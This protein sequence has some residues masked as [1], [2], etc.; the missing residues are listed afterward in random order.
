MDK[1]KIRYIKY[2]RYLVTADEHM[3]IVDVDK[4]F[5]E[6][7]G[8]SPEEA[9]SMSYMSL[10]PEEDIE[11]Q[12]QFVVDIK[13]NR[14]GEGYLEHRMKRK[15]GK[16]GFV[17][18]YGHPVVSED[19]KVFNEIIIADT[20]DTKSYQKSMRNEIQTRKR[21]F[22]I[23]SENIPGGMMIFE[24]DENDH[25][26]KI[27]SA[28]DEFYN[29][30]GWDKDLYISS[31]SNLYA[32]I[33]ILPKYYDDMTKKYA[34][35]K[36][37]LSKPISFEFQ[38]VK[39][40]GDIAWVRCR[41]KY[42]QDSKETGN[43]K[44]FGI[45]IDITKEKYTE[46]E[47]EMKNKLYKKTVEYHTNDCIFRYNIPSQ[48]I[49]L[50]IERKNST[51]IYYSLNDLYSFI[52]PKHLEQFKIFMERLSRYIVETELEVRTRFCSDEYHWCR[53]HANSNSNKEGIYQ[54]DGTVEDIEDIY[55]NNTSNIMDQVTGFY[56]STIALDMA[57]EYFSKSGDECK[58]SSVI[59]LGL[60]YFEGLSEFVGVMYTN[61]IISKIAK[62]I[63][64]VTDDN[65][66]VGRLSSYEFMIVLKNHAHSDIINYVCRLSE[67]IK[68][69][70]IGTNNS[71][72][73]MTA[74]GVS[75]YGKDGNDF[76]I[77]LKKANTA[78]IESLN[79]EHEEKIVF[80]KDS[81]PIVEKMTYLHEIPRN[82]YELNNYDTE[83]TN[84]TF[85]LLS[86]TND[87]DGALNIILEQI[88]ERYHVEQVCIY[89]RIG[90]IMHMTN[91]WLADKNGIVSVITEDDITTFETY[92]KKFNR[93]GIR[94]VNDT[95]LLNVTE[96]EKN[97]Y[98]ERGIKAILSL[99]FFD[100]EKNINGSLTL[101]DCKNVREWDEYEKK[102]MIEVSKIL[103]VFVK[104]CE[105]R[106]QDK[107]VI[108]R[109]S[110]TDPLTGL[111]NLDT[112]KKKS[113]K[114]VRYLEDITLSCALAYVD[115]NDF[116]FINEHFGYTTGNRILISL[117]QELKNSKC[118]EYACRMYSDDFLI[119]YIGKNKA[120]IMK[121]IEQLY[122]R[123]IQFQRDDYPE[124]DLRLNVGIYFIDD[125]RTSIDVAVENANIARKRA[126]ADNTIR[127]KIYD[128]KIRY[129]REREIM[130]AGKLQEAM[131][132]DR[133]KLYLQPKFDLKNRVIVGAEA[134]VRWQDSDGTMI[135]PDEFI[136][137]LEHNGYI[138]KL[139]FHM[140][141]KL[142]RKISEW[143]K[144]GRTIVPIS[145]NFSRIHTKYDDFVDNICSIANK[146]GINRS[147][148]EI[149]IT[150]GALSGTNKMIQDIKRLKENGFKV[151]I[152]DFGTGY[153][154]LNL[155]L[156]P[157]FD[158]VKVDKSI[159]QSVEN[160]KDKVYV[161]KLVELIRNSEKKIVFEGVETDEQA[162]L[163]V[164][165]GCHTGQG[166]L[167]SKPIPVEEFEKKYL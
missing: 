71:Y 37:D 73:I 153:S 116:A 113:S 25:K 115:L 154:S 166:Y 53:I 36:K 68:N 27:R 32:G 95:E 128:E 102:T 94:A 42:F 75:V 38:F 143:Q 141:E 101:C 22:D 120:E 57:K 147:V 159:I 161:K 35:I 45:I 118:A 76:D 149:E 2:G 9:M 121:Q 56:K 63:K 12:M 98:R 92:I 66:I 79:V 145:V 26:L 144:S 91:Q 17:F 104:L 107:A 152:D 51:Q 1:Q 50:T 29:I 64:E 41:I 106:E 8:Y 48:T 162:N 124:S 14:N 88:A 108:D 93:Y 138:T 111:Y 84:F 135:Y 109:L 125:L 110:T 82:S 103:N 55:A 165:C 130:I 163:L 148:V 70:Y 47:L 167:F 67:I 89:K 59:L 11:Q 155:L 69:I 140:Y 160:E 81:F 10:I 132:N 5:T 157:L 40:N 19:G 78:L 164:S 61:I 139:D 90:R 87:I 146:Y 72:S 24:I 131:D 80:Y 60:K 96:Y 151:D 123:L 105:E 77:L 122:N 86:S 31:K 156:E 136:P 7:T 85:A 117:G 142:V 100:T 4:G 62:Q 65:T 3:K 20:S 83:F 137:A 49:Y 112:F 44:Y 46:L 126:K 74:V 150:E 134:L 30:I 97:I 52:Y 158:V 6:I 39:F 13:N 21:A 23:L 129:E 119:L 127:W 58:D 133:F 33:S 43:H 99:A 34:E 18:C 28:N 16:I 54:I 114:K 15:D